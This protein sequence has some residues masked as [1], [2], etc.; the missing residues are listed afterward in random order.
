MRNEDVL[1]KDVRR[2]QLNILKKLDEVC[3]HNEL[4]YYLAFGTCL[5]ALRHKGFIPRDDD[6][7][8]LMPYDDAKKLIQ[9]QDQ[10]GSRYFIQSKETDPDYR[11]IAMRIRDCETTCIESDEVALN[12]IRINININSLFYV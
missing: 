7:D 4:K 9:L 11:S 8:V 10:F 6:I 3:E 1:R 5:G 2:I 12:I